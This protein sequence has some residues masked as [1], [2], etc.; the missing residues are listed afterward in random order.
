MSAYCRCACGGVE[1]LSQQRAVQQGMRE[2]TTVKPHMGTLI[3][4]GYRSFGSTQH[5]AEESSR[6]AAGERLICDVLSAAV[7]SIRSGSVLFAGID[8]GKR[9]KPLRFGLGDDSHPVVGMGGDLDVVLFVRRADGS[10]N[11]DYEDLDPE[12]EQDHLVII[13]SKQFSKKHEQWTTP[14]QATAKMRWLRHALGHPR[15]LG[16]GNSSDSLRIS[17]HYVHT[18]M[19]QPPQWIR[20]LDN[21]RK[22]PIAPGHRWWNSREDLVMESSVALLTGQLVQLVAF[23]H[24]EYREWVPDSL[25]KLLPADSRHPLAD[26]NAR[27]KLPS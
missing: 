26:R 5:W 8:L 23:S 27:R 25:W 22:V 21:D 15:L 13:D 4:D 7:T 9:G 2:M 18:G 6:G 11:G 12:I 20:Y 16:S 3:K 17:Y 24:H 1:R 10:G 14:D 19:W